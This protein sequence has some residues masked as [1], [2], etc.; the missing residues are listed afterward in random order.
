MIGSC[1]AVLG[2]VG[3]SVAWLKQAMTLGFINYP[4][5]AEHEPFLARIQSQPTVQD[6]FRE[7]KER[8]EAF[9]P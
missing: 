2:M 9:E 3:E 1:Y 8:W 6:V 4:F 5:L 7:I